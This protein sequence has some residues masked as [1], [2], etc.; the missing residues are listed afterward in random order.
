MVLSVA[1]TGPLNPSSNA[2]PIRFSA[3]QTLNLSVLIPSARAIVSAKLSLSLWMNPVAAGCFAPKP[4]WAKLAQLFAE[5]SNGW[6]AALLRLSEKF[7]AEFGYAAPVILD[8]KYRS[9][10]LLK[11]H[12][13]SADRPHGRVRLLTILNAASNSAENRP[14]TAPLPVC[15]S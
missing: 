15:M 13:A 10:D 12:K 11:L 14:K 9:K 7:V 3:I 1:I 2:E 8:I 6:C 5:F 4:Q